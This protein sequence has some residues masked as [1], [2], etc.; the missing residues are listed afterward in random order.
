MHGKTY[1][2]TGASYCLGAYLIV[3]VVRCL[4]TIM[5]IYLCKDA[6]V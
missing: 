5:S 1:S 4:L 3:L 6:A 2:A